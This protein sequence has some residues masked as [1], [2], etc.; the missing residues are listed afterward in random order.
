MMR[1]GL[2]CTAAL[3]TAPNTPTRCIRA[4]KCRRRSARDFAL[5]DFCEYK[6]GKEDESRTEKRGKKFPEQREALLQPVS[7]VHVGAPSRGA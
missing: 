7:E 4:F 1:A 6:T 5:D 2:K 3:S